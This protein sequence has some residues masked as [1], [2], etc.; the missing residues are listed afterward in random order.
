MRAGRRGRDREGRA[1]SGER[2]QH[3]ATSIVILA[4]QVHLF[5]ACAYTL[6]RA[7]SRAARSSFSHFTPHVR[8]KPHAAAVTGPPV[9]VSA[10]LRESREKAEPEG[11]AVAEMV[12]FD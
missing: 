10:R 1:S 7:R 11:P 4:L 8:A 5:S 3:L 2:P 12:D 9:P 6:R